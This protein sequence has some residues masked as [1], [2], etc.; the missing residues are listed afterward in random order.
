MLPP[1]LRQGVHPRSLSPVYALAL[2][3]SPRSLAVAAVV[4]VPTSNSHYPRT[5]FGWH[6]KHDR[7]DARYQRLRQRLLK[8][9]QLQS[10]KL[11]YQPHARSL[12]WRLSSSWGRPR[13][14]DEAD[15]EDGNIKKKNLPDE[16]FAYELSERE[17]RWRQKV[18]DFKK[19]I[20]QDPYEAMFGWSNR[21]RRGERPADWPF[22]AMPAWW[23]EEQDFV[24]KMCQEEGD[25]VPEEQSKETAGEAATR[26]NKPVQHTR[27]RT[28]NSSLTPKTSTEGTTIPQYSS[29]E[30]PALEYDPVSNRM[31]VKGYQASKQSARP[32]LTNPLMNTD[33]PLSFPRKAP[34]DIIEDSPQLSKSESF[35]Q[36]SLT[37]FRSRASSDA[38]AEY[39]AYKA[40][41]LQALGSIKKELQDAKAKLDVFEKE[42]LPNLEQQSPIDKVQDRAKLESDFDK[43]HS[44]KD[45]FEHD[46]FN[47]AP[48]KMQ[49]SKGTVLQPPTDT[50]A[51]ESGGDSPQLHPNFKPVHDHHKVVLM[52]LDDIDAQDKRLAKQIAEMEKRIDPSD[53]DI[54]VMEKKIES[55]WVKRQE[56]ETQKAN[57]NHELRDIRWAERSTRK[58]DVATSGQP[59]QEIKSSPPPVEILET[60]LDRHKSANFEVSKG[61]QT[62][63]QR[64]NK[65][66]TAAVNPQQ[67]K[68]TLPPSSDTSIRSHEPYGY[69]HGRE[70]IKVSTLSRTSPSASQED[71]SAEPKDGEVELPSPKSTLRSDIAMT[72]LYRTDII[73]K[74]KNLVHRI[75]EPVEP[76]QPTPEELR[77]QQQQHAAAAMLEE[78]VK[79]QKL[80]MQKLEMKKR[81]TISDNPEPIALPDLD[82]IQKRS[83]L[84]VAKKEQ[85]AQD[86]QLVREIRSIYEKQYGQITTKHRQG[87]DID[88]EAV[89]EEMLAT[90]NQPREEPMSTFSLAIAPKSDEVVS[91]SPVESPAAVTTEAKVSPEPAPPPAPATSAAKPGAESQSAPP[92]AE[93][94]PAESTVSHAKESPKATSTYFVIL[95]YDHTTSTVTR[96]TVSASSTSTEAPVPLTVALSQLTHPAKFLPHLQSLKNQGFVLVSYSNSLLI[97]RRTGG[98]PPTTEVRKLKATKSIEGLINQV[99]KT[100]GGGVGHVPTG[101][102]ASPTGFVNYNAADDAN[103]DVPPPHHRANKHHH[104]R[105]GD[106]PAWG[107]RRKPRRVER[108]FS[109]SGGDVAKGSKAWS[110]E[111]GRRE[112][113]RRW[114]RWAKNVAATFGIGV[115]IVYVAGVVAEM[116][117]ELKKVTVPRD[118]RSESTK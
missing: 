37:P 92:K 17:K 65:A 80:A 76:K 5:C 63:I 107:Y 25:A 73:D 34:L 109:G 62:A 35:G 100:V 15:N 72:K 6:R 69:D 11:L 20:D 117:R 16:G 40:Q 44:E 87:K 59:C 55:L 61:L 2:T 32:D 51:A 83:A 75:S 89:Q 29:A 60:A 94:V 27:E 67:T 70:S 46:V 86:A 113:R 91:E 84:D 105:H 115:A 93:R 3:S 116:R 118:G 13:Q 1:R 52:Q 12:G 90:T 110:R 112:L 48:Y 79:Q 24:K 104:N 50:M 103:A 26:G 14:P 95:A 38:R 45:A 108:V 101:D 9:K 102:F 111:H 58:Q 97:L 30:E 81:S 39:E 8:A 85:K 82:S 88:P 64:H 99:D 36:G 33:I 98:A 68:E 18:D 41:R 49:R 74:L 28:T 114:R 42:S 96:A 106:E 4:T 7:L 54:D 43:V 19:W 66:S 10:L 77:K 56:L 53:K 78:E 71:L 23:R 57:L 22:S 47:P 21:L 31:V